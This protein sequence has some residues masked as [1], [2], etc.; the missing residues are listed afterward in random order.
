M[1]FVK[2]LTKFLTGKLLIKDK[3]PREEAVK[4]GE[5]P[6]SSIDHTKIHVRALV[7]VLLLHAGMALFIYPLTEPEAS[8]LWFML[9]SITCF[10]L[11][12]RT[13]TWRI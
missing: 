9:A 1:S 6:Y 2:T 11:T 12:F 10:A 13:L 8:K 5:L 4:R 3:D 7:G